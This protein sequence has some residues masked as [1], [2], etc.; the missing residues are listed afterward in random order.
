MEVVH[1]AQVPPTKR[2]L[3]R[4]E[5]EG[6]NLGEVLIYGLITY[7]QRQ[8]RQGQF[9]KVGNSSGLN[10]RECMFIENIGGQELDGDRAGWSGSLGFCYLRGTEALIYGG[11]GMR[12]P[13]GEEEREEDSSLCSQPHKWV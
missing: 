9:Q 13:L 1:P 5:S 12:H 2:Q 11:K 10:P 4:G 6:L 8:G 7:S 3:L